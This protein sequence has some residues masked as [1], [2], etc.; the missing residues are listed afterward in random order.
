ML[1]IVLTENIYWLDGSYR[2]DINYG[3]GQVSKDNVMA[4]GYFY[5]EDSQVV[6]FGEDGYSVHI[7]TSEHLEGHTFLWFQDGS[8]DQVVGNYCAGRFGAPFPENCVQGYSY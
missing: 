6:I 2:T 7:D 8:P 3:I 1:N 5:R 4:A